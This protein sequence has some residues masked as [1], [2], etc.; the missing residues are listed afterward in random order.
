M[1]AGRKKKKKKKKKGLPFKEGVF[2]SRES[3]A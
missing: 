3:P 1:S 2:F